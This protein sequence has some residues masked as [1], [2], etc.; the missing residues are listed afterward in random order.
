MQN[1][2]VVAKCKALTSW[3]QKVSATYL[4]VEASYPYTLMGTAGTVE[5]QT[6]LGEALR[7]ELSQILEADQKWCPIMWQMRHSGDKANMNS[8]ELSST[9]T[10]ELKIR[11][12][13][14]S[15]C[16]RQLW[17]IVNVRYYYHDDAVPGRFKNIAQRYQSGVK[18]IDINTYRRPNW[19]PYF[20]VGD[21]D[22]F[23][24]QTGL[25]ILG[26][27]MSDAN[28]EPLPLDMAVETAEPDHFFTSTS[29]KALARIFGRIEHLTL[30]SHYMISTRENVPLLPS[31]LAYSITQTKCLKLRYLTWEATHGHNS[32]RRDGSP[33][34]R[35]D[36]I[37]SVER[38]TISQ[39]NQLHEGLVAFL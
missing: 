5:L 31:L 11:M 2:P 35:Q 6:G 9:L 23:G 19:S 16:L 3:I 17:N 36:K 38:I 7:A 27:A 30:R 8:D 33:L 26:Q 20:D 29:H 32:W 25:M 14:L 4:T 39:G 28:L 34:P 13:L 37:P 18:D 24:A 12:N 10:E 15:A 1:L 21:G 22:T